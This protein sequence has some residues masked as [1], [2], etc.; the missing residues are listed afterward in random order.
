MELD[1]GTPDMEFN[2]NPARIVIDQAL[3]DEL[4]RVL[5]S[6]TKDCVMNTL[7]ISSDTWIKIKRGDPIRRSTA[8]RLLERLPVRS[9]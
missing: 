1:R 7:G 2:E 6:H 9:N 8:A 5:H 3:V 4:S